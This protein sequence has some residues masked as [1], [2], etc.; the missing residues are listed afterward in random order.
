MAPRV[1]NT[2]ELLWSDRSIIS[3][4]NAESATSPCLALGT[5]Q[6]WR[7]FRNN[8]M[9]CERL[10]GQIKTCLVNK[11]IKDSLDS[12]TNEEL[13]RV[14]ENIKGYVNSGFYI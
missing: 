4:F 6:D 14:D 9:C 7:A 8:N 1:V 11:K 12:Q 2:S 10:I 13:K 3:F 5:P